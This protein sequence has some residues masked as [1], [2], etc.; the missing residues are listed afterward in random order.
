MAYKEGYKRKHRKTEDINNEKTRMISE[1][2]QSQSTK[3]F[4]VRFIKAD[5][6]ERNMRVMFRNKKDLL[7]YLPRKYFFIARKPQYKVVIDRTLYE[8]ALARNEKLTT[9]ELL[10][11]SVRTINM[12][13]L[14]RIAAGGSVLEF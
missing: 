12:H 1:F 9:T 13:T 5:G 8:A 6:T 2:I 11:E 14:S 7:P 10:S 4:N 3:I